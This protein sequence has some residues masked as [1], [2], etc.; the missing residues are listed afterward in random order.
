MNPVRFHHHTTRSAVNPTTAAP[1][2][3]SGAANARTQEGPKQRQDGPG[4][5]SSDAWTIRVAFRPSGILDA[6]TTH[7]KA[8]GKPISVRQRIMTLILEGYCRSKCYGWMSTAEL[9]AAYGCDERTV[10]II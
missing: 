10:Q 7:R 3:Q 4:P 2:G 6:R 8:N 1:S 9:A 5:A